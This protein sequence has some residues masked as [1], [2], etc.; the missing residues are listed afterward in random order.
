MKRTPYH[1]FFFLVVPLAGGNESPLRPDELT[2]VAFRTSHNADKL[3]GATLYRGASSGMD[4]KR[5]CSTSTAGGVR[6]V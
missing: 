4:P 3:S 5:K 6:S 2:L 1:S